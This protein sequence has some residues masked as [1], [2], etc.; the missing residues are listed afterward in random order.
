MTETGLESLPDPVWWTGT[1]SEALRGFPVSYVLT[2]R[3]AWDKPGH[4]YGAWDGFANAPD[5]QAFSE[6]DGIGLLEAK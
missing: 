2:W 4:F 1:L 3:N 6:L 5:F